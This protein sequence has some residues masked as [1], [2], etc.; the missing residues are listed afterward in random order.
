MSLNSIVM[1]PEGS[2]STP[3]YHRRMASLAQIQVAAPEIA[4]VRG[5]PSGLAWSW[6]PGPS[7]AKIRSVISTTTR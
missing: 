4:P 3:D 7:T 6:L 2:S 5:F 1:V